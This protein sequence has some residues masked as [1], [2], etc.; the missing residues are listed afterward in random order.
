MHLFFIRHFNDVD[1]F[2][3]IVWRMRNNKIPVTIYCLN[4]NYDI[5]GDYR[6]Q[7][8]ITKGVMV[9]HI[10]DAYPQSLGLHHL[11]LRSFIRI[12]FFITNK[13]LAINNPLLKNLISSIQQYLFEKGKKYFKYSKANFYN[14][15]WAHHFL[16]KSE[17]AVL[18]FDW[19]RSHKYVVDVLIKAANDLSIPVL[20]LPHGVFLYTNEH[21][22]TGSSKIIRYEKYNRFD[23]VA[24][25]N[26]LR[27]RVIIDSG[28]HPDKLAVLGSARYCDEWCAINREIIPRSMN[29]N[30]HNLDDTKLKIVFMTTRPKYR[31]N[32]ERIVKTFD[33]LSKIDNCEVVIKPHTRTG[34]EADMYRGIK[35]TE[36]SQLSSVELCEWADVVLVIASSILIESLKM[37]KPSLY[38]K[39]LHENTME[40]EELNSCWTI[41]SDEELKAALSSLKE[42]INRV[43]YTQD[44]VNRFLTEIIYGGLDKRDVLNDYENF[45]TRG[46]QYR[47]P[48]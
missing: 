48:D 32:I 2:T 10:Y 35:L 38:L 31:I 41:N 7:F 15:V 28:V 19:I 4:P 33:M 43:P 5:K 37:E 36:V 17:A 44:N 3:P 24:V 21:I 47:L 20:S 46:G 11:F 16:V 34:I 25:Q 9:N 14:S 22:K 8:L 18:C 40:Y 30:D 26:K 45:I 23:H 6:L 13:N 42:D 1:H 12:C 39:Y 29:Y 27:K